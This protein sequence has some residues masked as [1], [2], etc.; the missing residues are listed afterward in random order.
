LQQVEDRSSGERVSPKGRAHVKGDRTLT[1]AQAHQESLRWAHGFERLG[2]TSRQTVI[3]MLPVGFDAVHCWVGLNWLV[4]WEVPVNTAFQGMMLS[5]TLQNSNAR[6]A[7]IAERYLDRIVAL[8]PAERGNINT[9]IVPDL[10]DSAVWTEAKLQERLGATVLS[11]DSFLAPADHEYLQ[12]SVV[13]THTTT[14]N[15]GVL[16]L[17]V[18]RERLL[19]LPVP[20]VPRFGQNGRLHHCTGRDA[21]RHP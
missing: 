8:D 21:R 3:S 1:Y 15:G 19:L 14:R 5:Y 9:V 13:L 4:A 11:G 18:D 17:D 6:I 10:N 7:V 2:V 16:Y 20:D 12:G